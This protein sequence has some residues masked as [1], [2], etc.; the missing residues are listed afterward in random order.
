[1]YDIIGDIH[2]HADHLGR[3]LDQ[4]GYRAKAG[5]YQHPENK[6]IFLGDL[7]DRGPQ[8][9]QVLDIV[10]R[11][12][13][14]GQAL[15]V[16][17]NHE[18]NAL[19]YHTRDV[20]GEYLRQH[21]EKNVRQ[22]CATVEQLN[23]ALLQEYLKWFRTLP[24]WLELDGLRAVH[25][26]WCG[27]SMTQ[28]LAVHNSPQ[29]ITDDFLESACRK[30]GAL[31]N[32]V[33]IVLKGREIPLPESVSFSDKN[34][35]VRKQIRTRWYLPPDGHTYCSYA[36]QTEKVECDLKIDKAAAATAVPYS[37]DEKP[38][39]VGH[40]WL[41]ADR[42]QVLAENV[43]CLDFSVAKGGLLCAYRWRGELKLNNDH[44]IWV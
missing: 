11:M 21:S 25:A 7:I 4:L 35:V 26:C 30:T 10:R 12:V 41:S 17:G 24:L 38:V 42:P 15:A 20:H 1:M 16:M 39:F 19:A 40:Y 22:H 43:A 9:P 13:D 34:G 18:L 36:L 5:V 29:G 44:F 33:E 32:E 31:Y 2:G 14:G 37:P 28:I 3:L 27:A 6:V 8:I 23:D